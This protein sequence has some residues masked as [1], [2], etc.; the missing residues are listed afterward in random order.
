[1]MHRASP[2]VLLP[3]VLLLAFLT[4]CGA[5]VEKTDGQS[6]RTVEEAHDPGPVEVEMGSSDPMMTAM[7]EAFREHNPGI[8]SVS[9]LEFRRVSEGGGGNFVVARGVR[10]RGTPP[11]DELFGVFVFDDSLQNIRRTLDVFPTPR[12]LDYNV[13]I[14]RATGESVWV[15]GAAISDSLDAMIAGYRWRP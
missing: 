6:P 8:A 7:G 5:A 10:P 14:T 13:V 11:D 4:S 3:G 9:L 12:W 2:H 1:M 15:A